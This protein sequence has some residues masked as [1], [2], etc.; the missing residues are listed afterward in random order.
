MIMP[1]HDFLKEEYAQIRLAFDF[2]ELKSKTFLITGSNGLIGS[3]LVNVLYDLNRKNDLDMKIIAHSFSAPVPWLPKDERIRYLCSDL[4]LGLDELPFDFLIHT[5]TYGQPKKF[6]QNKIGTVKLNTETLIKLLEN[7]KRNKAKVLFV[8][9]SETYGQVPPEITPVKETYFGNVD[10]LSDRAVYAESKRMA[11]TI[12]NIFAQDGL[13]VKIVRL[14][15]AY[16]PGI[17]YSDSRFMNE[18]I[19]RSLNDGVLTMMD[20]GCAVRCFCFISD[21][22]EM[23]LN[24][25]FASK[26][27]LYNLAGSDNK[28]IR[29]VAEMITSDLNVPLHLPQ[30]EKKISGTPPQL[31]LS[32]T[33]YCDELKKYDFI[34][35]ETGLK[36]TIKWMKLLKKEEK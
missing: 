34:P 26:E 28:T 8:S 20:A 36:K 6:I 33:K 3:N 10:T 5:A 11:E 24:T 18:F 22:I 23:M 32:N 15:I 19:K 12:C 27:I 1:L 30:E 35:L 2:S 29:E 14:A 21:M 25:M 13:W 17:K 31:V 16:G 7:A 4:S 9:S